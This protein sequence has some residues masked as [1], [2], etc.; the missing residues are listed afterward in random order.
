MRQFLLLFLKGLG[1]GSA[2]IVPGISGGTV[3]FVTGIYPRLLAAI[4]ACNLRAIQLL[5]KGHWQT[6]W[7]CLD[8]PFLLP[9]LAGIATSLMTTARLVT[10]CLAQMPI[11]T[12]SCFFGLMLASSTTV[13]QHIQQKSSGVLLCSLGGSGAALLMACLGPWHAPDTVGFIALAGSLAVCAMLLPGVSGSFVLLL[14]GKYTLMLQALQTLR[15]DTLLP[16]M[17]GGVA[18]LLS[19]ARLIAWL[20][21]RFHDYT[22]ATLAGFMVGSLPQLW[23]WKYLGN[24]ISPYR[25]QAAA[26]QDPLLDQALLWMAFGIVLVVVLERVARRKIL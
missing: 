22:V 26:H 1:M 21:Q 18:G 14:L 6:L 20:L 23:P 8:G 2:D 3:A 11:Q 7:R 17:L 9:L 12:W 4:Q 16:F 19:F 15:L 24:N 25:L 5:F 10:Y 13:Y